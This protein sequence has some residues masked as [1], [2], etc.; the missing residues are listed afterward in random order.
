[1]A[2][3][4]DYQY[5]SPFRNEFIDEYHLHQLRKLKERD[6]LYDYSILPF[7]IHQDN[8]SCDK[9][10]Y[11]EALDKAFDQIAELKLE[12]KELKKVGI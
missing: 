7:A 12:L 9:C 11:K 6:L 2:F 8:N 1:M 4:C 10:P 5:P 3:N